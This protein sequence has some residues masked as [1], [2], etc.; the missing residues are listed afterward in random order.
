MTT[1]LKKIMSA[2]L[3]SSWAILIVPIVEVLSRNNGKFPFDTLD[4]MFSL[5]FLVLVVVTP[6][7]FIFGILAS[8]I[9]DIT[10]RKW[11]NHALFRFIGY[12]LFG[13][14][15]GI[16]TNDD[17]F[18]FLIYVSGITVSILFFISN[19]FLSQKKNWPP[20]TRIWVILLIPYLFLFS[21]FLCHYFGILY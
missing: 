2:L 1:L 18:L 7:T 3:A 13:T 14:L 16:T 5:G 10:T 21:L 4:T 12:L 6:A 20:S 11:A 8:W 19:E 15:S 9:I 17:K